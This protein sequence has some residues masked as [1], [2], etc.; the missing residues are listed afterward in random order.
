MHRPDDDRV[1]AFAYLA[2]PEAGE[3]MPKT[4]EVA[5]PVC[6]CFRI[7]TQFHFLPFL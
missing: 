1:S 5:S 4:H 6:G 3:L 2:S 7:G